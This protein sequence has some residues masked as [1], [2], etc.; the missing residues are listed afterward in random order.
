MWSLLVLTA[1]ASP[2][3][4]LAAAL[5][6]RDARDSETALKLLDGALRQ[7]LKLPQEIEARMA[8]VDLVASHPD[9]AVQLELLPLAHEDLAQLGR[10]D[11]GGLWSY[12]LREEIPLIVG[13]TGAALEQAK[14]GAPGACARVVPHHDRSSPV[15]VLAAA[16]DCAVG[17]EDVSAASALVRDLLSASATQKNVDPA[18]LHPVIAS[19]TLVLT[20]DPRSMLG[21]LD[22]AGAELDAIEK[23]LEAERGSLG[24]QYDPYAESLTNHRLF[25]LQ[26][27]VG[28]LGNI[29]GS[30]AE[31]KP[32]LEELLRIDPGNVS[33][34]VK[35]G[36]VLLVLG[37]EEAGI[38]RLDK[39]L[40]LAPEKT[41][42]AYLQGAYWVQQATPLQEELAALPPRDPKRKE[43]EPA[44]DAFFT[45]ARDAFLRVLATDPANADALDAAVQVCTVLEDRACLKKVK[46]K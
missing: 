4:D 27:R 16:L 35:L 39:A 32:L 33:V 5:K 10:I 20:E 40:A 34:N 14:Q 21:R 25:L 18:H 36:Q 28:V 3:K 29:D 1:L 17:I 23:R 8:R 12:K 44:I 15:E 24:D 37:E 7:G 19:A 46:P 26:T 2:K 11:P 13:L 45:K 9:P 41:V 31:Q 43:L 6:A 30:E 22:K 42:A 38:A